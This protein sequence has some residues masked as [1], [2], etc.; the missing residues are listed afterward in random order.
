[1]SPTESLPE[2][3]NSEVVVQKS[4]KRARLDENPADVGTSIDENTY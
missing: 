2:T 3:I 1:M 4:D